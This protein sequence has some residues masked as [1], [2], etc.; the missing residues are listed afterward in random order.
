MGSRTC[1]LLPL[2][3]VF[4]VL[5]VLRRS[6]TGSHPPDPFVVKKY[7]PGWRIHPVPVVSDSHGALDKQKADPFGPLFML[8]LGSVKTVSN[9]SIT[10]VLPVTATSVRTLQL[11]I[12]GLLEFAS[13]IQEVIILCPESL[14][15]VVR[16]SIR[17][18]IAS[19]GQAQSTLLTV[20][21]C[22]HATCAATAL[23]EI[24]FYA[25][26]NWTLFLEDCGPREIN[27]APL[28]LLLDQPDVTFPI[29]LQGFSHS[30]SGIQNAM[31]LTSSASHRP[32]DF[33]VPPFVVP[34]V[35]FSDLNALP[36]LALE[37]WPALGRWVAERRPDAIG[38]VI[39]NLDMAA[40][41]CFE[42]CLEAQD[43][44]NRLRLSML[45]I[46]AY[47]SRFF[48][49]DRSLSN[50]GDKSSQG[51]F[52]IFFPG[53]DHLTAFSQA[54]CALVLRGHRLYIFLYTEVDLDQT[55]ISANACALHYYSRSSVT[56]AGLGPSI[57]SWISRLSDPLDVVI[58]LTAEDEFVTSLLLSVKNFEHATPT[59]IR[60]PSEDLIYS[61][62]M[63]AL[64]LMEWRSTF[65]QFRL[66]RCSDS[67]RLEC[68][69]H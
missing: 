25:S 65:H 3:L 26:T 24:G 2:A 9:S 49:S 29:G 39:V 19:Y 15:S 69:S 53:L 35:I 56:S 48:S 58:A 14:L 41:N 30:K 8:E 31:P 10:A 46:D 32:A 61:D 50:I 27:R 40:N 36:D 57:S 18:V 66:W 51:H 64:S 33:L 63:G 12:T 37:S 62:W 55:F 68:T 45:L 28:S 44:A 6:A 20:I 11:T 54:A 38:G 4:S 17:H 59:V 7:F 21:P 13:A 43:T 1:L 60:L 23:I 22:S 42:V 16:S 5:F 47:H 67:S 34:S 52:G